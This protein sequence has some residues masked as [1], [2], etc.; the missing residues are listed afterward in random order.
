M[1]CEGF[2]FSKSRR[3][4]LS[5]WT[6]KKP[7]NTLCITCHKLNLS[8][9]TKSSFLRLLVLSICAFIG[10]LNSAIAQEYMIP[11]FTAI[12]NINPPRGKMTVQVDYDENFIFYNAKILHKGLLANLLGGSVTTKS[13]TKYDKHNHYLPLQ[14]T[15]SI[16]GR[17][18]SK[19]EYLFDQELKQVS[20]QYDEKSRTVALTDDVLDENTL[21]LQI[22]RDAR[23]LG[24]ALDKDY[25]IADKGK[26]KIRRFYAIRT[27]LLETPLG[28][29]ETLKIERAKRGKIDR[30]MWLSS[31]HYFLPVKTNIVKDGRVK[32]TLS[33]VKFT[34]N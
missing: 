17:P 4:F 21:I 31:E 3:R 22:A 1:N 32:Q 29:I 2:P 5:L 8:G 6:P 28:K 7:D 23:K 11:P 14:Y 15:Y 18:N 13:V 30:I 16:D 20:M 9:I 26:I 33:V 25:K 10:T 19:K 24:T 27:E 12:Y 34:K